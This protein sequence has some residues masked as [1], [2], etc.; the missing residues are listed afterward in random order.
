M[1]PSRWVPPLLVAAVIA[2]GVMSMLPQRELP[3]S[4]RACE[5]LEHDSHPWIV[6]PADLPRY[7]GGEG[8]RTG[9]FGTERQLGLAPLDLSVWDKLD[10]TFFC[11]QAHFRPANVLQREDGLELELRPEVSGD[12]QYTSGSIATQSDDWLYGRFEVE[13]QPPKV[14]GVLTA[15][16]LYRFDP[17]QEIDLEFAGEDTTRALLNVFY[18]PGEPGDLYNYG[19]RGTPV[20]VDLGFD[21]SLAPHTYAIEWDPDEIRWFADGQLIHARPQGAPTPVPHLP[22]RFHV[23]TWPICSEELAGPLQAGALPARA[24]LRSVSVSPWVAPWSWQRPDP[25][26]WRERAGWMGP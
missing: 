21:A 15:F 4:A 8:H 20:L 5:V 3:V 16:F 23:N 25:S 9:S 7:C 1:K 14:S 11:N 10:S 18:N 17:W 24:A 19:Y 22:M 6:P 26:Q 13:L 2:A 12:R